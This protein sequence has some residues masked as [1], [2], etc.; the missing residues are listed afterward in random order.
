MRKWIGFVGVLAVAACDNTLS[1]GKP[2]LSNAPRY[3]DFVIEAADYK[4]PDSI[5]MGDTVLVPFRIGGGAGPCSLL[6]PMWL[7][8]SHVFYHV[9][10]GV[11]SPGASCKKPVFRL[12]GPNMGEEPNIDSVRGDRVFYGANPDIVYRFIVCKPDGS[13]DRKDIRVIPPWPTRGRIAQDEESV[14]KADAREC[15]GLTQITRL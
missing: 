1:P 7:W 14:R 4:V 12:W 8:Q 13:Y 5:K 3:G 15:R 6:G 11:N 10:W 2:S 9:P